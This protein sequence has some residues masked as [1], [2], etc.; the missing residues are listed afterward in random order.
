MDDDQGKV[1]PYTFRNCDR[2]SYRI[3][4]MMYVIYIMLMLIMIM[5]VMMS[6]DMEQAMMGTFYI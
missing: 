4:E 5:I 3:V 6:E 2:C 1:R